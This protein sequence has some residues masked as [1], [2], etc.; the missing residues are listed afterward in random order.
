M[1]KTIKQHKTSDEFNKAVSGD[2]EAPPDQYL[3]M[4]LIHYSNIASQV[5]RTY[6]LVLIGIFVTSLS[7]LTIVLFALP[8][9]LLA[10]PVV[11]MLVIW[12]RTRRISNKLLE[13]AE[14]YTRG[15][16]PARLVVESVQKAE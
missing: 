7:A 15:A 5:E 14:P 4:Q 2:E 13:L 9:Y 3:G 6:R 16:E 11:L 10:A 12:L 1:T 8:P